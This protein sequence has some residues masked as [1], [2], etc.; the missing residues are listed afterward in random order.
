MMTNI[1]ENMLMINPGPQPWC[2]SGGGG[3]GPQLWCPAGA[4][5]LVPER[6]DNHLAQHQYAFIPQSCAAVGTLV[7][8]G[9]S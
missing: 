6:R 8:L 7:I 3:G 4:P 5:P 9:D 1:S 2:E